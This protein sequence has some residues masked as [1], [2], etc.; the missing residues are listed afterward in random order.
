MKKMQRTTYGIFNRMLLGV[1][2]TGMLTSYYGC[3]GNA[4]EIAKQERT[5]ETI[6]DTRQFNVLD[7]EAESFGVVSDCIIHEPNLNYEANTES[8]ASIKKNEFM[9]ARQQPLSTFSIDVDKASYSNVRRFL[10]Q[11]QLPTPKAVRIEEMIN[12]FKYTYSQ[13]TGDDPFSIQTELSTCPWNKEH[14]LVHIG[15]QG[16]S[17][18]YKQL[19]PSNLVF[20]VDVSSSMEEPNKLPLLKSSLKMLVQELSE[21]DH[22]A[23]V[24]YAGSAGLVL[25][26]TSCKDKETIEDAIDDLSSGGSTAGGAGI[27]LAYKIAKENL[28]KEGNNRVILAT[29]GDFNV[30]VSNPD[31]LVELITKKKNESIFLT[32]C[33]FGTGNYKDAQMEE[34][35]NKGNGNY[36]YIDNIQ[37]AK[38]VFVTEMRST[39]FTIAKD[40]KIQVEF[41]P[42]YV[43]S[44][45]LVGYEDRL[46]KKEDFNNDKKDAGELGAGH[47][48]T[49]LYEIVPVGS[50][51]SVDKLKYQ[52]EAKA[53]ASELSKNELM[54]LKLRYKPIQS[55]ESKLIK[56]VVINKALELEKTSDNF[57]FA[58]AVAGFGMLLR[59]S[60]YIDHFTYADAQ[61]LAKTAASRDEEGYRAECIRLMETALLLAKQGE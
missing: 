9:D 33:G 57:R 21:K 49:A 3:C 12:Y 37:E 6:N 14:Q 1:T 44:Y 8:Y 53:P 61:A 31:E 16:K 4:E 36:F 27:Q 5:E 59:K 24:A 42:A 28:I 13:P 32:I 54:Q 34:I 22:V 17:I 26:S 50:K 19:K 23:L 58:S 18:D 10:T 41:N 56:Q 51:G 15:I 35:S 45:R 38:K 39:L 25:P 7:H 2:I 30:G 43:Q 20:L 47:T 55:N 29:D 11:N 40:V 46:L 48:V 60:D 52:A